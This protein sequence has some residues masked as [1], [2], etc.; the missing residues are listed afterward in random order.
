M[1]KKRK[2]DPIMLY[3]KIVLLLFVCLLTACD[4]VLYTALNER[5]ANEIYAALLEN[6]I[7]VK[8]IAGAEN[9]WTLTIGEENMVDA[10]TLLDARGLPREKFETLGDIFKKTGIIS[11]PLEEKA[12][13]MYA[14][15]QEMAST[16]A[17]I[18]GVLV[19]KV[20]IVPQEQDSLG[21]KLLPASAS[22]FIKYSPDVDLSGDVNRIKVL[23]ENSIGGLKKEHISVFLFQAT[24]MESG[25]AI[26]QARS[27]NIV[28]FIVVGIVVFIVL[29][30]GVFFIIQQRKIQE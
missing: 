22:I 18:D 17:S 3:C 5:D 13:F 29:A 8:K 19:A 11:T 6:G 30:G 21:S 14:L 16:I 23:V 25:G 26:F 24:P 15:S 1:Y 4:V 7:G 2:K 12:R 10:I 20:H 28:I 9:T 27:N